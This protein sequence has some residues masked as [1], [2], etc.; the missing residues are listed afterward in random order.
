[1]WALKNTGITREQLHEN[2]R[3]R[4]ASD[5]IA[6]RYIDLFDRILTEK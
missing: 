5:V 3:S 1:M 4:F 6:R 2:V